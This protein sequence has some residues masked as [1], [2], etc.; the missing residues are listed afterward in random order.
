M[1]WRRGY[2]ISLAL[3]ILWSIVVFAAHMVSILNSQTIGHGGIYPLT[4][5]YDFLFLGSFLLAA[6]HL[7]ALYK[8]ART[9]PRSVLTLSACA[10]AIS[11]VAPLFVYIVP[12]A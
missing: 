9:M 10:F 4:M 7:L 11:F 6:I 2:L 12:H 1:S 5:I 8:C 3:L